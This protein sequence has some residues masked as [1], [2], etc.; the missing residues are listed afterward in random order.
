[1]G[2]NKSVN[3]LLDA[4]RTNDQH[5]LEALAPMVRHSLSDDYDY[6]T[7]PFEDGLKF[8]TF[9]TE[10]LVSLEPWVPADDQNLQRA[11]VV[12][13]FTEDNHVFRM[14]HHQD[15]CEYVN[16]EEFIGEVEDLRGAMVVSAEVVSETKDYGEDDYGSGTYTFYKIQTNKGFV[17][18][19][20]LGESNGY[21]SESVSFE[22]WTPDL[23]TRATKTTLGDIWPDK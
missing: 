22:Q 17:T 4:G 6:T 8:G 10:V 3:A 15:C 12:Y 13:F 20:W 7:V 16:L 1:M 18:M 5:A 9:I 23:H 2:I 14:M 11:D 21:Y 19:R